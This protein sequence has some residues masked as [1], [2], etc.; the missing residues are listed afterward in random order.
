ME[1]TIIKLILFLKK[2]S[3]IFNLL[4]LFVLIEKKP[5]RKKIPKKKNTICQ[6][7]NTLIRPDANGPKK[8]PSNT[9]PKNFAIFSCRKLYGV[10]SPIFAI[11]RG[12]IPPTPI[13]VKNLETNKWFKLSK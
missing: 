1:E 13:P 11:V 10:S 6:L 7:S 5:V 3:N 9:I 12:I 8:F 2:L 4:E